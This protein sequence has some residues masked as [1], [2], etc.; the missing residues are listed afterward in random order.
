MLIEM[1]LTNRDAKTLVCSVIMIVPMRFTMH[2]VSPNS[3]LL[4]RLVLIRVQQDPL[5]TAI[6]ILS[7]SMVAMNLGR[8][9]VLDIH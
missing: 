6:S 3:N 9:A 7:I 5:S 4:A 8:P 1:Q 2:P